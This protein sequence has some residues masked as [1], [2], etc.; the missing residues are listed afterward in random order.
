VTGPKT[1]TLKGHT[2][3]VIRSNIKFGQPKWA[4]NTVVF[5]LFGALVIHSQNLNIIS[6]C[7]LAAVPPLTF[8]CHSPAFNWGKCVWHCFGF[9]CSLLHTRVSVTCKAI[10]HLLNTFGP[11]LG[12]KK[13]NMSTFFFPDSIRSHHTL[14]LSDRFRPHLIALTCG[15]SWCQIQPRP[16]TDTALV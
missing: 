10:I 3:T 4:W 2:S 13:I 6:L 7:S 16:L 1:L 12:S 14:S 15:L 5:I 8:M 11:H 9:H